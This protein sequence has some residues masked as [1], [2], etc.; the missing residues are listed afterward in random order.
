M[1]SWKELETRLDKGQTMDRAEMALIEAEMRRW[2]EVL[3]RLVVIIQSLAERN[4]ALRGTTDKLHEPN[5]GNSA[6]GC[7]SLIQY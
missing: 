4:I 3:T 2:R 7:S 6:H 5:N 1:T